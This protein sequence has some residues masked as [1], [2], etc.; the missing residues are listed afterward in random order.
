MNNSEYRKYKEAFKTNLNVGIEDDKI[1]EEVEK[2]I[3]PTIGKIPNSFFR[4]RK[5]NEYTLSEILN[6]TVY[7]AGPKDFDDIFDSKCY[8]SE[9]GEAE[10][11]AGGFIFMKAVSERHP[12]VRETD[13]D[14]S[15]SLRVYES[16]IK[17]M[18]EE[19]DEKFGIT[20]FT[21]KNDNI[22]MWAYYADEHKGIC[23][24]YDF[25]N[26]GEFEKLKYLFL[27][28]IYAKPDEVNQYKNFEIKENSGYATVIRNALVKS[29]D[30][31]FEKEWRMIKF[32]NKKKGEKVEK[33]DRLESVKIKKIYFGCNTPK[34]AKIVISNIVEKNN[35]EIELYDMEITNMGL[36]SKKHGI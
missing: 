2:T 9:I 19:N 1:L 30:W 18:N 29:K 31:S 21:Q 32:F 20:C 13:N 27:P 6:G 33:I 23:I 28:V 12:S 11:T 22:P 4:Y 26:L 14:I 25:S 24:E 10:G 34:E 3:R 8:F 36:K 15:R 5:L 7:L 16:A 17:N 35:L